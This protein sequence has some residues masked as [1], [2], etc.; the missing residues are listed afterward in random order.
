MAYGR[1]DVFWPD[2][3]FESFSLESSPVSVG[4]SSGNT[5]VLDTDTISRYHISIAQDETGITLTDMESANGTFV[6]GVRLMQGDTRPL[7]GGEEI[8][9]GH[10]R[11]TFHA[12]DNLPT[13][14]MAA[15]D[16]DTQ[17]IERAEVDFKAQ[18]YGPAIAVPP[19]SYTSVELVLTNESDE[20]RRFKVS[21]SGMPEA[22]LKVNRPQLEIDP[23]DTTSVLINIK[24]LRR[25]DSAPGSYPLKISVVPEIAPERQIDIDMTAYIQPYTGFGLA[26]ANP[27]LTHDESFRLH[28]HNQGSIPAPLIVT[29]REPQDRLIFGIPTPQVT[30]A[31][32]ERSVIQGEIKPKR[33]RLFGAP[34]AYPFDL[35]VRSRD[36]AAFLVA[37]PGQFTERPML[38]GWAAAAVVGLAALVLVL[39]L[40]ALVLIFSPDPPTPVIADFAASTAEAAQGE[41]VTLTWAASDVERFRLLAN[42][43]SLDANIPGE[44]TSFTLDTTPYTGSV[45]LILEAYND[46]RMT[47]AAFALTVFTPLDV[48]TLTAR[49]A[50]L[51]RDVVQTVTLTW[52][53]A[54]AALTRVDGLDALD[55]VSSEEASR[56]FG[57]SGTLSVTG[58]P[59]GEIT[60]TLYAEDADGRTLETPLVLTS[61]AP[62]CT[63]SAATTAHALPAIDSEQLLALEAEQTL[64]VDRRNADTSWL[65][66][67][68]PGAVPGWVPAAD[69][70]CAPGFEM[71]SLRLDTSLPVGPPPTVAPPPTMTPVAITPGSVRPAEPTPPPTPAGTP[72]G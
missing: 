60:L 1:L 53:V 18:A 11:L 17:R 26:L 70:V 21:A 47:T 3:Q 33:P 40:L 48:V 31:P 67:L 19:G 38:P 59:P 63:T 28:L 22:W 62:Q 44:V 58:I 27:R 41:T 34:R 4:R 46:E 14:P 42:G 8:Q 36:E 9:I 10:L 39:V 64:I 15:V 69:L 45:A 68:L 57:A 54:G 61:T 30:L 7:G 32:G 51:L 23:G 24:P 2:G 50:T 25:S 20:A 29:G 5:I 66:A 6:D 37:V 71:G 16:D 35:V 52:E 12:V 43:T 65:R 72:Q 55:G 56:S 49:P 13:A